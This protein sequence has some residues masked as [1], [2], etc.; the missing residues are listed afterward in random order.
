LNKEH[1]GKHFNTHLM[2]SDKTIVQL[3]AEQAHNFPDKVAIQFGNNTIT[4]NNL[5]NRVKQ[6]ANLLI[7]NHITPGDKV[8]L[9]TTRCLEM[10]VAVLAINLAGGVY[11]PL[12]PNF[13]TDRLDFMLADSDAKLLITSQKYNDQFKTNVPKLSIEHAW[14]QLDNYPDSDPNVNI[15]GDSLAYLLYTSGSTGQPKG[16]QIK[17]SSLLNL[18]TSIQKEPGLQAT[19]TWLATATISFDISVLELYLPLVAGAKLIVADSEM[20]KD[21]ALLLNT[22]RT[23]QVTVMQATPYTWRMMLASGWEDKLPLKIITGGEALPKDLADKLLK[24]CDTLWNYYGPTETTIY[25][26]G[27][28]ILLTDKYIT[29]GKPID[30][31]QVYI[32][33]D[34]LKTVPDGHEG[35]ICI[36]GYGVG[37]GYLNRPELTEEKFINDAYSGETTDKIYRTGDL[38][39]ILPNGEILYMGRIDLQVKLRGYRIE[40]QEIEY[41]LIQQPGVKNAVVVVN[42]DQPDNQRLVAYVVIDERVKPDNEA[43]II[44]LKGKLPEYMVPTDYVVIPQ[45]PL[46]PNGKIDRKQL[47][48]PN[49]QVRKKAYSPPETETERMVTEMWEKYLH[50][51]Q[52]GIH[53]NFFELGGHSLIAVQIMTEIS[54][55]TDKLL[56]IATLFKYPTVYKLALLLQSGD[57]ESTWKSLV[58]IKPTGNKMP[59]YIVHGEGLNVLIFN[60]IAMNVDAGQPVYGLQSRG[61]NGVDDVPESIE[62]IAALYIDEILEQN[63]NGPY[64]IAGYS[65]G[66]Y[67]AIEMARQLQDKGKEVKI[68]A[69]LDVNYKRPEAQLSLPKLVFTKT[70]RQV[71]KAR[72]IINSFIKQPKT[73]VN[74][75]IFRIKER[76]GL[77]DESNP[78][79]VPDYMMTIVLKL[80]AAVKKYRM[81][82]FNGTIHLL[83]SKVRVYFVDDPKHLG[84]DEFAQNGVVVHEVP[85]DHRDMLLPPNDVE[86]ARVLQQCLDQAE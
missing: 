31:T 12:D 22:I 46:T 18:L 62:G 42:A 76:L 41:N 36:G 67:V 33:N 84:W 54:K 5:C 55:I 16:V 70:V 7:A 34:A 53:D 83:R 65:F 10:V 27:K 2:P 19:D 21:G 17:H 24:V 78:E 49:L 48:K 56:P 86:F 20:V 4:Y 50:L 72:F 15:T 25:S 44:A 79:N 82:P 61:L 64:A 13:P 63:P 45:M 8:A 38:G 52:V 1:A 58:A 37:V 75:Q 40:T 73:A 68:L 43:W 81:E 71:H 35:E 85:G 29:I 74:Y 80:R 51:E 66:G 60:N 3:I 57:T 77:L 28:Q 69:M 47:P 6:L 32:L 11:I 30:N 14:Q 23:Q 9:A 39:K 26:T 59:V